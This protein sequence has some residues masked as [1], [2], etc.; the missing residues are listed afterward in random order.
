MVEQSNMEELILDVYKEL[1][2]PVG[3][4]LLI[5]T[6]QGKIVNALGFSAAELHSG[7]RRLVDKGLLNQLPSSA[8]GYILRKS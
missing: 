3:G 5:N 8:E 2:V 7:L 4:F 1:E 6:L